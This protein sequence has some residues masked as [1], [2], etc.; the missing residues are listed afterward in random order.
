MSFNPDI[1]LFSSLS[2]EM[3]KQF[4]SCNWVPSRVTEA[5]LAGCVATGALANK[6][7]IHWRVPGLEFPPEPQDGE[8]I[9]FVDHLSRGFTPPGSNFF[10]WRARRLSNPSPRYRSKLHIQY[11]WLASI[12]WSVPARGAYCWSVPGFLLSKPPYWVY[13]WPQYWI[14]WGFNLEEE[15]CWFPSCQA[16]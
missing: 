1:V 8:V 4:C 12:L 11:L 3:A 15:R 14:R 9:V 6:D 10:P 5:Q 16:S 7:T 13:R 2:L